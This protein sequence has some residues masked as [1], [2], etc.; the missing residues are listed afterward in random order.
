MYKA[1]YNNLDKV[2]QFMPNKRTF[3][4]IRDQVVILDRYKLNIS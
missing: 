1:S 3:C 2:F 4:C